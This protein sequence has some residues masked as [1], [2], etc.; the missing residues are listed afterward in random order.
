MCVVSNVQFLQ[1]NHA[2]AHTLHT[3]TSP[4][5]CLASKPLILELFHIGLGAVEDLIASLSQHYYYEGGRY[6]YLWMYSLLAVHRAT[7]TYSIFDALG[8]LNSCLLS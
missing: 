4:A 8:P 2:T 3:L 6:Y 1:K 7:A 5:L